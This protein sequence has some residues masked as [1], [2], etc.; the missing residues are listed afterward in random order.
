M[1]VAVAR[2]LFINDEDPARLLPGARRRILS[3]IA[4]TWHLPQRRRK[5]PRDFCTGRGGQHLWS[6][7]WPSISSAT[8]KSPR[9]FC[10]GRG[11]LYAPPSPSLGISPSD[12]KKSHAISARGEAANTFGRYRRPAFPR[13]RRS[14]RR[15]SDRGAAVYTLGRR[16]RLAFRSA[17]LKIP[18]RLLPGVR[19]PTPLAVAVAW[20][21]IGDDEVPA[22]LLCEARRPILLA[23]AVAWHFP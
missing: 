23:V 7:R 11:G 14:P 21:L 16:L 20:H 5:I 1:D 4:V 17:S 15:G 19:R 18:A 2:H 3:A 13:R 10:A 8:T 9:G 12:A 6:S 22:R